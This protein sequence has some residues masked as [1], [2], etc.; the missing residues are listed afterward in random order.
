MSSTTYH[1]D[2]KP[3][4]RTELMAIATRADSMIDHNGPGSFS[5]PHQDLMR[6]FSRLAFALSSLAKA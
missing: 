3:L 4:G 1:E 6:K 5:E 2:R